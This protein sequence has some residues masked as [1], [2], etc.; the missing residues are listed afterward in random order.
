MNDK[1]LNMKRLWVIGTAIIIGLSGCVST[2]SGPAYA[3][4]PDKKELSTNKKA[5]AINHYLKSIIGLKRG[6]Y[7]EAIENLRKSSDIDKTSPLLQMRLLAIYYRDGDYENAA[8]MAERAIDRAPDS[9]ILHIWL[10]RIYNQ[11]GRTE[12]SVATFQKAIDLDPDSNV[13]YEA[14]AEV[15]E[16]SNDLVGAV[17]VYESM[18]KRQPRSA[19]LHYRLGINLMEMNDSEGA[20]FAVERALALDPSLKLGWYVLGVVNMELG[21][22]TEAEK[23]FLEHL[24]EN[25][26]HI[27]T[28]ENLAAIQARQGNFVRAFDILGQLVESKH[29]T[30]NHHLQ[31]AYVYLRDPEASDSYIASA[32]N[33]SPIIGSIL[34]ILVKRDKNEPYHAIID[35]L[36]KIEGDLDYEC[37]ALL[38]LLMGRYGNVD[39]GIYL[40]E[41]IDAL[42][43]GGA[44]SKTLQMVQ[45]RILM[46]AEQPERALKQFKQVLKE[47]GG[48]KWTHFYLATACEELDNAK[49]CEKHLR[50][51]LEYDPNDPDV[52]NFLSYL[53]AEEDYRLREAKEL[54]ERALLNDP[55]NGFYLDTLGW[56]YYRQGKGKEAVDYIKRAIRAMN[57][58]DAIL[59][60][61]LG[62]AYLI[63]GDKERA[64]SEWKRAIRLDPELKSIQDKIDKHSK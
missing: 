53:L 14:L 62:D 8:L 15:E 10:G 55:E 52:L 59:R 39:A 19:L 46:Y 29:V 12:D 43:E 56:I 64:V 3:E 27:P 26:E 36:D 6:E 11:L 24:N 4:S 2:S 35:S 34:Q 16:E 30:V 31:R 50:K 44:N 7:P 23:A 25:N 18:I 28:Y 38:G 32:P 9:I 54:V 5:R 58:D 22:W 13:A 48:D 51:T 60:D 63:S 1:G 17:E 37:N 49:L 45:G 47:H 42:I 20:R 40:A 57:S 41:R 61:H 33:D 21:N